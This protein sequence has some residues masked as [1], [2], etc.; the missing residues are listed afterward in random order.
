MLEAGE[1]LP[2]MRILSDLSGPQA[3]RRADDAALKLTPMA[4]ASTV[5]ERLVSAAPEASL[6]HRPQWLE[7]LQR[8]YGFKLYLASIG[9]LDCPNV[10][11]VLAKPA[12]PFAHRLVALPGSDFCPP[13]AI[14]AGRVGVLLEALASYRAS[15]GFELRGVQ[16]PAPWR[17]VEAYALWTLNLDVSLATLE[18]GTN[19]SFRRRLRQAQRAGTVIERGRSDTHLERFYNL[20]I[21]ARRR[22]GVPAQPLRFFRLVRDIFGESLEIWFASH[23]GQDL[24]TDMI[25]HDSNVIYFRWNA[26]RLDSSPGAGRLLLWT[27]FEE[28]AGRRVRADFGR[29]DVNNRGVAEFKQSVGAKATPL[30]YAFFP[31]APAHISREIM[32]G[33]AYVLSRIWSRL[34]LP[35]ARVL[36]SALYRYLA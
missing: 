6:Y 2:V 31:K 3:V 26:R 19:S 1:A 28:F 15:A 12:N 13:L 17:T 9:A 34:P 33:P 16:A 32:E 11:C 36:G 18:R 4:E 30:P 35:A 21:R 29:T 8:S 25:V 22:F 7:L 14:G 27:V 20:Y 24:V 10:A 23:R 5:W